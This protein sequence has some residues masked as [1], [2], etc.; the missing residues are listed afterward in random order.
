MKPP[1][2]C[3]MKNLGEESNT[4]IP[5]KNIPGGRK[6]LKPLCPAVVLKNTYAT[7]RG[8]QKTARRASASAASIPVKSA[9]RSYSDSE[10]RCLPK[11]ARFN[12]R[13]WNK[14]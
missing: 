2:F 10:R 13:K 7:A 11:N 4:H 5:E 3:I 8:I 1:L 14:K 12:G 6:N 9:R